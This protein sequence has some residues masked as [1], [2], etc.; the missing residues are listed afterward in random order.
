[1]ISRCLSRRCA[2]PPVVALALLGLLSRQVAAQ[3]R[4][5]IE[6]YPYQTAGRGEWELEAHL[7][8]TRLGITTFD[9][10]V[11]PTQGQVRLA[12]ELTRGVTDS[13]ELSGYLLAARRPGAGAE[14]AGWRVRSR[15]RAPSAWPLPVR[16][17]L[18]V[19]LEATQPAYSES[20][21]TLELVPVFEKRVGRWQF[22]LDPAIERDLSGPA[23]SE[24]WELEPRAR[25]AVTA[26]RTVTLALEY[27]G[28]LGHV[29]ALLPGE[30]QVHQF[31]PSVELRVGEDVVLDFGVG[32]GAT[33]A[34]DRLVFKSRFEMPLGGERD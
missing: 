26:S 20:P 3:D 2:P 19:E 22:N 15:L 13:W 16:L 18:S 28:A 8:Y 23:A 33:S 31:F 29:G 30:A 17:G 25:A 21:L 34:G 24:G 27:Y 6:V 14:F 12:T 1:M 10:Q 4:F 11:A 9:G 7:N 5:E 32:V